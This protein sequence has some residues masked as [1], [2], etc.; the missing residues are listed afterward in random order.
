MRTVW[1][2][3][4]A[5]TMALTSPPSPGGAAVSPGTLP[6]AGAVA[7]AF[8]P[9]GVAWGTGHRGVDLVA[10]VDSLVL[11]PRDGVVTFAEVLAGRPV[12][13]LSHGELRSTFEPVVPLVDVGTRVSQG[14]PIG[15]LVAGHACPAASC[16]HW[17]LK[18]GEIYLNPLSLVRG[19]VRLLSDAA[20][21]TIRA[22]G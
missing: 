21:E 11:A 22:G 13:V 17:G 12:L 9:P 5:A 3:L 16:L 4:L 7:T 15:R 6:V 1:I 14:Q 8:D 19:E 18:R 20:A 10:D 2:M